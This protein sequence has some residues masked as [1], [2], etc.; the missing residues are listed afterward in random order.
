[1]AE[2]QAVIGLGANWGEPRQA[3][4]GAVHALG[5][6]GSLGGVRR[7]SSLYETLPVGP[8]QPNFL[9]A[10][11]L[12]EG[13]LDP[14]A[15]LGVLQRLELA[16]GRVRTVRWGPRTLDLDLLWVEGVRRDEPRLTLPHPRLPER[17][18]ALVP[19]VEVAPGARDPRSGRL[20]AETLAEL[21]AEGVRLHLPAEAWV[22]PPVS[23]ANGP[24]ALR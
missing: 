7:I 2:W 10:A 11:V 12:W 3:L 13:Q 15:L 1:M 6:L 9:N 4:S 17:A 8:P 16:A 21:G 23:G 5:S 14:D 18:F 20:Y 22:S 19:L 24:I